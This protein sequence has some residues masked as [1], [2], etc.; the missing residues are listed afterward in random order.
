MKDVIGNA[1]ALFVFCFLQIGVHLAFILGVGRVAKIRLRD[2]LLASNAN[3][4][5]AAI[6]ISVAVGVTSLQ[7]TSSRCL[8]T[9]LSLSDG[10]MWYYD[11]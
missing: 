6:L 4:G 10:T 5:G 2:L 8:T 3:V 11:M 7:C 1:P 9:I